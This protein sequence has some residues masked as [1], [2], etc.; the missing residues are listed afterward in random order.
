MSNAVNTIKPAIRD[1]KGYTLVQPDCPIKLNQ[2]EC[3]FDVPHDLKQ[4]ILT[5]AALILSG[6][7]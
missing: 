3:P 7:L 5:E 6:P 4:H 2:N 1:M